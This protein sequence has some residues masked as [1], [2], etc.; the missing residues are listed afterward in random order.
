LLALVSL[1][2]CLLRSVL[3]VFSKFVR[4]HTCR[5]LAR[6]NKSTKWEH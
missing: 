4:C 6:C 5:L 3:L 1:F 2:S